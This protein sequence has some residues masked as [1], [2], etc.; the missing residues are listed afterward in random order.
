VLSSDGTWSS[1][2]WWQQ[3]PLSITYDILSLINLIWC[4]Y[5]YLMHR[6]NLCLIRDSHSL[7]HR[8]MYIRLL[9]SMSP[10]SHLTSCIPIK[11]N[12]FISVSNCHEWTS[13]YRLLLIQRSNLMS[14]FL[15][16]VSL[17]KELVRFRGPLWHFTA[18]LL[19]CSKI[20]QEEPEELFPCSQES[21][22][23]LNSQS[24][25]YVL[26]LSSLICP[27][28]FSCLSHQNNLCS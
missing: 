3:L 6:R 5:D 11:Y 7:F 9:V 18:K 25:S 13:L 27:R 4:W 17:F 28:L 14:S 10:P 12:F 21:V 22:A 1:E 15:S 19:S 24:D 20:F 2:Q 23:G 8:K 26:I 16:L